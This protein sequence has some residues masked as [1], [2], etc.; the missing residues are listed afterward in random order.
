[1]I[2]IDMHPHGSEENPSPKEPEQN[3]LSVIERSEYRNM[4]IG[5]LNEIVSKGVTP[6]LF[7]RV[8][9]LVNR[10]NPCKGEGIDFVI[11]CDDF[12]KWEDTG[13]IS[14]ANRTKLR[15]FMKREIE[16]AL[17]RVDKENSRPN[18]RPVNCC[19]FC[20]YYT[21]WK[22]RLHQTIITDYYICDDFKSSIT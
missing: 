21:W 15:S 4:L 16:A 2:L 6:S 3:R 8:K 12:T 10:T 19:K 13:F 7:F 9:N 11:P 20:D 14:N 18:H 5:C 17:E 22:C 1:M